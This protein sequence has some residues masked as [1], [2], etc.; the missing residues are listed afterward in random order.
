MTKNQKIQEIVDCFIS[1]TKLSLSLMEPENYPVDKFD[2]LN[3][4]NP[5]WYLEFLTETREPPFR[6]T[7]YEEQRDKVYD[8]FTK[9]KDSASA[10]VLATVVIAATMYEEQRAKDAITETLENVDCSIF[11]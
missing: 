4:A 2:M 10:W 6:T 7:T 1:N 5:S 3:L 11:E 8:D 9:G